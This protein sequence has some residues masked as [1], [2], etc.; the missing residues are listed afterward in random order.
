MVGD[1]N[2]SDEEDGRAR[3]GVF[4]AMRGEERRKKKRKLKAKGIKEKREVYRQEFD[5]N[6]FQVSLESLEKKT[7]I[8]TGDAEIC[9]QCQAVFSKFSK[10]V[11]EADNQIWICEYCN[12]RNEVMID[13]E[14]IPKSD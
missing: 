2:A 9:A 7:E 11:K 1:F 14:E 6:V 12:H 5:T 4:K 8:A 3:R 10:I 13:D